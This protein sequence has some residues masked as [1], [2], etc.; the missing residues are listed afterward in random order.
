MTP[1][2]A[3]ATAADYADAMITARRA[4]NILLLVL[5]LMLL[6]QIALFF[7]LHFSDLLNAVTTPSTTQPATGRID[8]FNF[9]TNGFMFIALAGSVV[10]GFVLLLIVNIML[11]GRLIGVGRVTSAYI[12]SV[13]LL[14]LLF[15]WQFFLSN[16]GLTMERINW[17]IPGVL[18]TWSEL[19]RDGKFSSI[20]V[21]V[22][23]SD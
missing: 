22:R 5:L 19:I 15:P 2:S 12:W 3:I 16:T 13:I 7:T 8:L 20:G 17:K 10:L 6:G 21:Y 11:V 23:C 4:K 14:V 1:D 18:W 9:L